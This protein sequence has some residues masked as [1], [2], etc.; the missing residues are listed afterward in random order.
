MMATGVA[1]LMPEMVAGLDVKIWL[2]A[3]LTM[4]LN[5]NGLG[6]ELLIVAAAV[7]TVNTL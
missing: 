5:E 7:V 1:T 6:A 4:L 3:T 2:V